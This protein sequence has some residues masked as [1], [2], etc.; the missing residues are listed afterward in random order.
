MASLLS[1][2]DELL[3]KILDFGGHAT[4]V[5]CQQ[6]RTLTGKTL[7]YIDDFWRCRHVVV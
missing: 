4:I 5:V 2:P 1:L 7:L 3:T 6:V